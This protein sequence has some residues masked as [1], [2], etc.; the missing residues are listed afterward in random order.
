MLPNNNQIQ[1]KYIGLLGGEQVVRLEK[2][3]ATLS[4]DKTFDHYIVFYAYWGWFLGEEV[5]RQN[6]GGVVLYFLLHLA[7]YR[8]QR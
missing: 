6:D 2:W 3:R 4:K 8:T 7:R 5:A 1:H